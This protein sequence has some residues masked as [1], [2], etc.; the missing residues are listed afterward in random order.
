[1]P[2]KVMMPM[3][4]AGIYSTATR[5][6]MGGEA[7]MGKGTGSFLLDGGRGGQSSYANVGEYA[8]ATG[9][10]VPPPIKGM[11]IEKLSD[12]I[13]GLSIQPKKKKNN[14]KFEM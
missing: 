6:R 2:S 4:S 13:Q 7:V 1:M 14:I 8:R 5:K 9:R 12:K 10:V 11:G 3:C